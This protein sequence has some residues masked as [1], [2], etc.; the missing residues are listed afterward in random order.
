MR[1]TCA[2]TGHR[3]LPARY[4]I[5]VLYD[6]LEERILAGCDRFLCGMARGFDLLALSCLM[7]LR[8]RYP[9]TLVACIPYG[10]QEYAVRGAER[11]LYRSLRAACDEEIVLCPGYRSGCLPARDRYMADRADVVLAWCVRETGGTAYTV[12]YAKKKG[13]DVVFVPRTF[14][15]EDNF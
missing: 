12:S 10:G 4:D 2:L 1:L 6:A 15:K 14:A 8:K 3:E 5:N 7:D 9:L 13:V 11:E